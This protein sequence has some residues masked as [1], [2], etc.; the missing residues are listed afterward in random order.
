MLADIR[1]RLTL[2]ETT[3]AESLRGEQEPPVVVFGVVDDAGEPV[4]PEGPPE[5]VVAAARDAARE[6]GAACGVVLWPDR[7]EGEPA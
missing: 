7:T 1:R 3:A 2:L 6:T 5:S 4:E